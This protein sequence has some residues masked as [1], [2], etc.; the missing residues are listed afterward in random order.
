ME[1]TDRKIEGGSERIIEMQNTYVQSEQQLIEACRIDTNVW[2][3]ISLTVKAYQAGANDSEGN[4]QK[5]QLYSVSA[6]LKRKN[7]NFV[8]FWENLQNGLYQYAE[9]KPLPIYAASDKKTLI[10]NLYDAHIDKVT[11]VKETRK[12]SDLKTN[13]KIFNEAVDRLLEKTLRNCTPEN[14]IF[15]VG[16]D[17]INVNSALSATTILE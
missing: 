17:F 9:Y 3:V 7:D 16:N 11:R 1:T 5:H 2:D 6:R 12:Y 10:L 4:Y 15:P 8:K 14:I 13:C